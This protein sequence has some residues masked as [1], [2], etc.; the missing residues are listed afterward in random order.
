MTLD[1]T[2]LPAGGQ[3]EPAPDRRGRRSVRALIAGTNTITV[4]LL[5]TLVLTWHMPVL[6]EMDNLDSFRERLS[7]YA[8]SAALPGFIQFLWSLV[9]PRFKESCRSAAAKAYQYAH[10]AAQNNRAADSASSEPHAEGHEGSGKT[11]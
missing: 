11:K 10:N 5:V 9:I 7:W 2:A 4:L 6:H 8:L 3:P 1:S